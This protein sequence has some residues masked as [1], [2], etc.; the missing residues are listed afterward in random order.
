MRSTGDP[1]S[2]E[3]VRR[4]LSESSALAR[5][6]PIGA[7]VEAMSS[8]FVPEEWPPAF[9]EDAAPI[10]FGDAHLL[11]AADGVAA[12]LLEDPFW[13]GYCGVLVN[14]NDIAAMGGR[15]LAMVNVLTGEDLSWRAEVARGLA[16]GSKHFG[17]PMVGGHLHP[18]GPG[19]GLSVAILGVASHLI[20][21]CSA[22]PGH[23]IVFVG[24]VEGAWHD[25]FPN[26]DSTSWRQPE[27]VRAHLAL[28]PTLAEAGLVAAGKDVSNPGL[29]G[30]A[31]MMLESSG[32]GACVDVMAF[33]RPEGVGVLDWLGAYPGCGFLLVV[34]PADVSEVVS[35]ATAVGL[36]GA[37]VG[38]VVAGS[39]L[40]MSTG[41]STVALW[42][43]SLEPVTGVRPWWHGRGEECATRF[44]ARR[45]GSEVE[46]P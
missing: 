11:L 28:P 36:A 13:A 10:P 4:L 31:L 7:V 39:V 19:I 14:A 5:K 8:G 20:P 37:V 21:S 6:Q 42:D 44:G 35:R 18:D 15:P 25:P 17:I 29:L 46:I 45:P 32:A 16:F 3:A 40:S 43:H 41:G 9:C 33:P 26:W 34:C 1:P 12:R 27:Q 38:E 2:P 23:S 30:T 24:D 22:R